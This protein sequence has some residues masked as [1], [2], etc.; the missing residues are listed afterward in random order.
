MEA[1]PV[2]TPI[3]FNLNVVTVTKMMKFDEHKE[4]DEIFP[5]PPR[6]PKKYE[7]KLTYKV[8]VHCEN[9]EHTSSEDDVGFLGGLGESKDPHSADGLQVF[10]AKKTWIPSQDPH[11]EKHHKGQWKQEIMFKSSFVLNCPPSFKV[12]IMNV[13]VSLDTMHHMVL[14]LTYALV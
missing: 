6:D 2:L 4:D 1:F 7:L 8:W 14:A 5:E 13:E 3:P 11:D 10:P 9:H 12:E